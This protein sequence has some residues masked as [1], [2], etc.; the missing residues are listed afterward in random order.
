MTPVEAQAAGIAKADL[1]TDEGRVPY[2]YKDTLGFDT[3]AIGILVDHRRGGLLPEEIDFIFQNRVSKV[4][5][6]MRSEPWY[7]AVAGDPVRMAAVMNMQ[8]QLGTGSDEEFVSSF[9]CIQRRDWAGAAKNLRASLWA[10]K[11]T[12][13]RAARV[14]AMI[15]TGKHP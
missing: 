12:P 9:G 13:K 6:A 15:E 8:F 2:V 10:T 7:P 1:T 11:Q 5:D 3:I 14:I 4:L